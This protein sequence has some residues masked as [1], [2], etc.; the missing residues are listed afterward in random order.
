MNFLEARGIKLLT[1]APYTPE[2]NDRAEREMRTVVE[3]AR[4]M[5]LERN[6]P[7]RLWVKT[8]NTAVYIL[9]RAL[10][11][12]SSVATPFELW[13]KKK[14]NLAHLRTFGS[15]AFAFIPGVFRKKW[16]AKSWKLI[17]VGHEIASGNYRLF[18]P[19]TGRITV[20]RNVIFNKGLPNVADE[21]FARVSFDP[22]ENRDDASV[23]EARAQSVEPRDNNDAIAPAACALEPRSNDVQLPNFETS[24]SNGGQ[25]IAY[26][27]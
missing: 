5:L 11:A 13:T 27:L 7:V 25:E 26:N 18:D 1:S 8:V 23:D 12:R 14:P 22:N 21:E 10:G 19:Q 2:K 16:D 6:L 9:N 3:T 4:T 24:A 20:S 17:F 15:D